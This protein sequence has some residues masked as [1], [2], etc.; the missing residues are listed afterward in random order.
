MG[1]EERERVLVIDAHE[2]T[3]SVFRVVKVNPP[4]E[5][6][7]LMSYTVVVE[8]ASLSVEP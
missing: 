3:S 7:E 1:E 8:D 4:G 6:V 5:T 2:I